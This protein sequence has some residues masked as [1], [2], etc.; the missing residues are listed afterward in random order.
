MEGSDRRRI[1]LPLV[2]RAVAW[3]LALATTVTGITFVAQRIVVSWTKVE[4]TENT[5]NGEP[6][7]VSGIGLA[8]LSVG[9]LMLMAV[10]IFEASRRAHTAAEP[11]ARPS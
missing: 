10:L 2:A 8:L 4:G 5:F 11:S 1:S 7:D 6:V 9:L 3:L